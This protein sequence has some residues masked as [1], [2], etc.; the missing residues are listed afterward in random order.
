[1]FVATLRVDVLWGDVRSLKQKRSLM[2]PIVAVDA[3]HCL[4]VLDGCER[5][6]AAHPE[7]EVPSIKRRLIGPEEENTQ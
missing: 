2:R 6:I 4:R 5:L 1:M 3:E 7:R